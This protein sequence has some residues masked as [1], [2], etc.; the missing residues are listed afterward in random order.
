MINRI[1]QKLE[2]N[3]N[4]RLNGGIIAIPWSLP[5]LSRVLPGIVQGR[6]NLISANSKVGKTQITDFL[7]MYQ[8]IEWYM[9]NRDKDVKVKILYFSLEMAKQEKIISVISY[10]LFRDYGEIISPENLQSMFEGKILDERILK[11]IK[12]KPFQEWLEE[13]NDIVEFYDSTRN[14]FGI[15]NVVKTYAENHGHYIY[16]D[17]D[18]QDPTTGVISTKKVIDYYIPDN[19]NEYVIIVVDHISLLSPEKGES[20][21]ESMGRF[22]SEY[23]LK[24]RDRWNYIPTIVQQQAADSERQEFTK[25]GGTIIDK[26]K[27]SP[28]GLGD[29]K[30]VGRDVNLMLSL[31]WPARYGIQQYGGVPGNPWDLAR[32]GHNHRELIINLNRNGISSA[33]ID[34]MFLGACNYFAELPRDPSEKVYQQIEKYNR[35][36]I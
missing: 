21:R 2:D 5:R 6:Y 24:M 28:D 31:F 9:K 3:R 35:E 15:Y 32:I 25:S 22:S 4:K 27:P 26:L 20:L 11:I 18:W 16:K 19:P 30:A 36:T 13:F 10:K 14:P 34:L 33:S 29:N 1:I 12:S 23:C 7:Y 17:M 8:P